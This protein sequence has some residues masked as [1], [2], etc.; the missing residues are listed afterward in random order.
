MQNKGVSGEFD[1]ILG[2]SG[3]PCGEQ[4]KEHGWEGAWA[5]GENCSEVVLAGEI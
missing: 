3:V 1:C 5:R 4:V 2:L